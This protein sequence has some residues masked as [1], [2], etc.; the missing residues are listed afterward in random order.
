MSKNKR[1]SKEIIGT[2]IKEYN[3]PLLD[4]IAY[5]RP[6]IIW[7]FWLTLT[8]MIVGPTIYKNYEN[9]WYYLSLIPLIFFF[10]M[11]IVNFVRF[12]FYVN[13]KNAKIEF[14]LKN[15]SSFYLYSGAPGTGKSID[16]TFITHEIA[17]DN[18][19]ELQYEYWLIAPK[20]KD[21]EYKPTLDEQ[22]I[23]DAYNFYSKN[24]GVPCWGTNIP[25]YSKH[26]KRFSYDITSSILKQEARAPYKLSGVYDEIGTQLTI[27]MKDDRKSNTGGATYVTDF[28]KFGRHLGEFT[29]IGCEQDPSNTYKDFR[30]VVGEIRVFNGKQELL[31]PMFLKWIYKKLKNHF[32]SKMRYSESVL[33]SKFMKFLKKYIS[34]CGFMKFNYKIKS[35]TETGSVI[36]SVDTGDRDCVYVP[37]ASE[38]VYRSRAFREAYLA[39]DKDITLKAWSSLYMS[40]ER[41]RSMLKSENLSKKEEKVDNKSEELSDEVMQF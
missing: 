19:F 16:S 22:E 6:V 13:R 31:K 36:Y 27:E 41:A 34:L 3:L 25:A 26:F 5:Y 24:D 9:L 23:I 1:K 40:D 11:A 18:W 12:M 28:C 33:F 29:F 38:V 14:A 20:L 30:R 2:R 8:A 17:K 35:N 7:F 21:R 32:V 10:V 37:C 39:K 15:Q 4:R